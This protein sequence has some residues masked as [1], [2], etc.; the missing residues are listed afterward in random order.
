MAADRMKICSSYEELEEY[1]RTYEYNTSVRYIRR[2]STKSFVSVGI[3]NNILTLNQGI[4]TKP[5][6]IEIASRCLVINQ[7]R[8]CCIWA[9]ISTATRAIIIVPISTLRCD[10]G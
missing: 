2:T 7:T 4:F 6:N 5:E 1:I 9:A 10:A 8:L 3:N